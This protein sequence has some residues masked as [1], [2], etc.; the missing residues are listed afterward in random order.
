MPDLGHLSVGLL[1]GRWYVGDKAEPRELKA[2]AA[3][4]CVL[5]LLP[6][7]DL[8]GRGLGR[9]D[10]M[11]LGHRGAFHSLAAAVIVAAA[12][13]VAASRLWKLPA[14]RAFLFAGLVVASHGALDMLDTGNLGV[15]YLWPFT[16][17]HFFWPWRFL[18]G[19]PPGENW[20]SLQGARVVAEGTAYF[21]PVFILA[22]WPRRRRDGH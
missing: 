21:I 1:A 15:K 5:S 9:A 19:P 10:G 7:L 11:A 14:R 18:P 12:C 20:L 2:A 4:F 17:R 22:L 3:A 16:S 8:I 6:D 13:A